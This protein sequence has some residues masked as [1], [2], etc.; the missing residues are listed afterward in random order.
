MSRAKCPG[1]NIRYWTPDD[2]FE[3][4]GMRVEH[5]AGFSAQAASWHPAKWVWSLLTKALA[6]P[7]VKLFTRT[8]VTRI[9]PVGD[10]YEVHTARGTIRARHVVLAT[11]SYT[12]KLDA[13]FHNVI[14]PM[15][16][17]AASGDGGPDAMK[18]HVGISASWF[19]AGRY[20][21]RVLF[22][23]GGSRLPDQQAGRNRPSR[24][25]TRFVASEMKRCFG[26]Y[27]LHMTNEWSGTVGYSPDEYPIVGSIDGQGHYIIGG[28]CGSGSG[29]SFNAGR[30]IVNRIL[31]I[32][33]EPDDYPEAYFAPSRLLDPAHH[34][35]PEVED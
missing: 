16:E 20:G 9:A 34:R 12:P 3:K 32:T 8:A 23:S 25:L 19:F 27:R 6:Q 33:D 11:E 7:S 17:Q 35:W 5:N 10:H 28:M 22:A 31:D 15:Q 29:V 21:R 18:P 2:V 1:Q 14:L 13:R 4:S 24:F 30:C 26:P